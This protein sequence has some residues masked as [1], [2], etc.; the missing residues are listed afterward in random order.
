[1]AYENNMDRELNWD[2]DFDSAGEY[3]LLKEQDCSFEVVK[4]ERARY[5]GGPKL[6]PCKM[7][8]LTI[9]LHGA[10]GDATIS[11]RLFL[12]TKMRPMLTSFFVSVGQAKPDDEVIRPQW[13]RLVGATGRC[14]VAIR[15]YTKKSG[16]HA[17]ETGQSNEITKFL[18][19][20]TQAA[21]APNWM[22]GAF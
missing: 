15:E 19:P 22:Q 16:P 7:A 13:D 18:P 10:E 8:L 14:H 6:P 17:G 3:L 11:H 20:Q 21:A 9:R 4:F 12:H 1:M 2:E 5:E